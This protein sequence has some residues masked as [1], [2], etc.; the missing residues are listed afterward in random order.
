M[1][2]LRKKHG[3]KYPEEKLHTWANL[4]QMKKHSSLDE[5]PDYPFF[6]GLQ[7]SRWWKE[8]K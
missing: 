2:E 3:G 1:D 6:Q 4:I 7:E 5:P 8:W